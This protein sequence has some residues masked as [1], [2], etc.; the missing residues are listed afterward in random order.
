MWEVECI[1]IS[2][3]VRILQQPIFLSLVADHVVFNSHFNMNS[4][5]DGIDSHL[6]L[7]PDYRP[8]GLADLIKPKCQVLY[9]PVELPV[10]ACCEPSHGNEET[11]CVS[12][13]MGTARK[14]SGNDGVAASHVETSPLHIVWPHRWYAYQYLRY[15]P[16][17]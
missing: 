16:C 17:Y 11:E 4:F 7:M 10:S 14:D 13:L 6:K 9:F 15:V 8:K 1:S 12:E 5:L 2:H 3:R